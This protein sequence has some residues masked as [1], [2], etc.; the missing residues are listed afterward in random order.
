MANK[1]PDMNPETT[2]DAT[3]SETVTLP[4]DI[5]VEVKLLFYYLWNGK[6]V[7]YEVSNPLNAWALEPGT[8]EHTV[9]V[10][11]ISTV[12]LA[13]GDKILIPATITP[14]PSAIRNFLSS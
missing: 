14:I 1:K 3:M 5:V 9:E 12:T 2:S 11:K 10:Q 8:A 4:S 7:V 13:D 6:Q